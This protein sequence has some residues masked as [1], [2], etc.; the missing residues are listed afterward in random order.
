MKRKPIV[1]G[2]WKMNL[3]WSSCVRLAQTISDNLVST[4]CETMDVVLCPPF[5]SIKGVSNV[6]DFDHAPFAV[7]AQ[8]V[9]WEMPDGVA[10]CTGDISV[11][12][13]ADLNCEFC[14]I[15]HSERRDD[16]GDTDERIN[17][18]A[19]L[20]LEHNIIPIICCGE[21][22]EINKAKQTNEFVSGQVRRALEGIDPRDIG[23]CVIAY[24][25]IW[26]IGTGNVPTPEGAQD[27]CAT[28]R[29]TLSDLAGEDIAS[30]IRILY[31]GSMKPE[32]AEVFL[33]E[34]DI[35]GGL[36][37]GAALDAMKFL[38]IIKICQRVKG[39][40]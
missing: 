15:G 16:N 8:D 31:G 20:L 35:D 11:E 38:D 37:G 23:R 27:V 22:E 17:M 2:N 40:S 5:T 21:S 34:N 24:E 4:D 19:R 18:K 6:I 25:P 3:T 7:G 29:N 9:H 36:I 12:M 32:N 1:A 28:I 30:E 39:L 33:K 10:A 14:I 13:L 26:A